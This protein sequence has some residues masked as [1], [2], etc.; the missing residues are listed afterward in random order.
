MNKLIYTTERHACF[1]TVQSYECR[2]ASLLLT[3]AWCPLLSVINHKC[4]GFARFVL[5]FCKCL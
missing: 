5:Y 2:K 4:V 1:S 3:G